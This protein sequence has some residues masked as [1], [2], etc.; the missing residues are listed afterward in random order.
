MQQN[1]QVWAR[2]AALAV[3][4]TGSA[5]ALAQWSALPNITCDGATASV[6]NTGS[7]RDFAEVDAHWRYLG[8]AAYE[9]HGRAATEPLSNYGQAY[10]SGRSQ[11][12]TPPAD[13]PARWISSLAGAGQPVIPGNPNAYGNIDALFRVDFNLDASINPREFAPSMRFWAD[14]SV[15][16]IMI[17][18]RWQGALSTGPAQWGGLPQAGTNNQFNFDGFSREWRGTSIASMASTD[19]R[20]GPNSMVVYVKSGRPL[21]G[22]MARVDSTNN[23]PNRAPTAQPTLSGPLTVGSTLTG[24]YTY[25]D[26]EA[27]LESAAGSAYRLIRS[28]DATLTPSS[29]TTSLISGTATASGTVVT[30]TLQESDVGQYVYYC[31]TPAAQTGV[32]PGNETCTLA[33]G[34]VTSAAV[35]P[36]PTLSGWMLGILGIVLGV[37]TWRRR[38]A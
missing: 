37:V 33:R 38:S 24:A 7:G 19:W 14:N 11:W 18:G 20:E 28:P 13:S 26:N 23:C 9:G 27:D 10:V 36:V 8:L 31:V 5:G 3:A 30:Y 2:C 32:S 1:I 35:T 34:P 4:A 16:D 29:V 22:F 17:N 15:V 25:A 12:W 21:M 6:L